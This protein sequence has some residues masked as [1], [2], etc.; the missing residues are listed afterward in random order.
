MPDKPADPVTTQDPDTPHHEGPAGGWGSLVGMTKLL[1]D[2]TPS[3][4]VVDTLRRQNK[5]GGHMYTSCAWAKPAKPH[6][7]AFCE[8]GAKATFWG[9]L[10]GIQK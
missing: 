9:P 6:A 3:A 5:P 8:N 2:E 10:I 7:A 4:A 1:L